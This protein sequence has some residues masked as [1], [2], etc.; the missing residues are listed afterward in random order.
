MICMVVKNNL[1]TL[2]SSITKP[3]ITN[4]PN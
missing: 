1:N 4:V 2:F 3:I